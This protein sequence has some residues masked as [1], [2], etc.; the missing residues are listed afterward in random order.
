LLAT[1]VAR[2]G[3]GD[4]V[5]L[6]PWLSEEEFR[7]CFASA[8]LIVFPS[9]FEGFGLPAAEAMRLGIPLVVTPEPALLEVTGGHAVVSAGWTAG[10]LAEAVLAASGTTAAELTAARERATLFTWQR[11]AEHA[12]TALVEAIRARRRG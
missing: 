11:T 10:A 5:E 12:R 6:L 2:R 9:D 1:D 8:G 4:D 7:T 3:L